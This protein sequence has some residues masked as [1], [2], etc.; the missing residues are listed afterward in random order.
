MISNKRELREYLQEDKNVFNQYIA[1]NYRSNLFLKVTKG[2]LYAINKYV[3]LLRKN[4]YYY[5]QSQVNEGGYLMTALYAYYAR[6][7][8]ILGNQ[9]GFYIPASVEIGKGILIFHH[10]D[11]CIG[12]TGSVRETPL[13]GNNVEFGFGA[14]VI[15]VIEII[16]GTRI[17]AGATVVRSTTKENLE[18]LQ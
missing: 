1:G 3:K 18:Y 11:N 6:K 16:D 8:N 9:L 10:D 17:G 7:K 13:N 4:Q 12:N 15:G 5:V 2:H 14:S